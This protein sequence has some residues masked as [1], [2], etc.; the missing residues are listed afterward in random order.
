M[1][2]YL[3]DAPCLYFS[4]ADD[5]TL[6]DVNDTLCHQLGY[7][8]EELTEQKLDFIFTLPTR[9]F[10]Q[11]HLFPLLKMQG[12][13]E[14]IFITLQ[15]KRKEQLPVLLNAERKLHD[16]KAIIAYIGIIVH[17]RKKFEDELVA[18]KKAAEKALH[19]NTALL[20]A[21][22]ELQTHARLL[23]EQMTLAKKQNEELRQMNRVITHDLQ[24]PLRKLFMFTNMLLDDPAAMSNNKTVQKIKSVSEQMRSILSGL[25]QYI[26][27]TDTLVRKTEIDLSTLF[28]ELLKQLHKEHPGVSIHFTSETLP[29][30]EGDAEQVWFLFHEILTNAIHFRK[31]GQKVSVHV[32]ANEIKQN[33][34]RA[35]ADK[36]QFTSFLRIQV[37]D[38]GMGFD[39]AYKDQVFELFRRLHTKSGR[40]IGL[41][42]CKK[43]MENHEGAISIDSKVGEE[44]TISLLF[45]MPQS[46]SVSYDEQENKQT[47]STHR[48]EGETKDHSLRG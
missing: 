20:R 14:E 21:R 4:S 16:G 13:A 36:Y 26:W 41:S 42:L 44:T 18:A 30:I 1:E 47:K 38:T 19:E 15:T 23:D 17:N 22:Q 2:A 40:G 34:F 33:S 9:I 48:D 35:I 45:P 3:L 27:L 5:G 29:M 12:H 39:A 43:I 25:Q 32:S 37:T 6:M 8:R 46:S 7:D 11:T 28:H 24:E 31:P 10:Q